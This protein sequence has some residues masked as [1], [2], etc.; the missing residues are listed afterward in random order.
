MVHGIRIDQ[1]VLR[2]PGETVVTFVA[3]EHDV[4]GR[5]DVPGRGELVDPGR[6]TS[7]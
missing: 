7:R 6:R 5:E 4:R 1:P 2:M 3:A